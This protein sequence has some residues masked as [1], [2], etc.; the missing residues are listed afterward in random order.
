[1][2]KVEKSDFHTLSLV[3][4]QV[5]VESRAEGKRYAGILETFFERNNSIVLRNYSILKKNSE[6]NYEVM[7]NGDIIILAAVAWCEI[8][9]KKF[10]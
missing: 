3:G 2:M 10:G 6:G 1:M 8:R 9:C 5:V 4:K 7:E